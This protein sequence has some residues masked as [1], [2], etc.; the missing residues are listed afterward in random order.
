MNLV[1]S[2]AE[3]EFV[4]KNSHLLK[5]WELAAAIFRMTGRPVTEAAVRQTRQ[6]LGIKK[7]QGRGRCEV[8]CRPPNGA[9]LGL[10]IR[11]SP[12]QLPPGDPSQPPSPE[13]E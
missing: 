7:A 10:H 12:A 6:R 4:A 8:L 9:G 11:V 2:D 1:W 13:R 5:D 3:K